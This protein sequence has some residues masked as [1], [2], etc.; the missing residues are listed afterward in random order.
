[1]EVSLTATRISVR[2]SCAWARC[3]NFREGSQGP[4]DVG[5]APE[6]RRAIEGSS[7]NP[8]VTDAQNL[9]RPFR[10]HPSERRRSI[11][12]PKAGLCPRGTEHRIQPVAQAGSDRARFGVPPDSDPGLLLRGE[13]RLGVDLPPQAS[14]RVQFTRFDPGS[15]GKQGGRNAR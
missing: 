13:L 10:T 15:L 1:M 3:T 12:L 11:A 5:P 9:R 8:R 7:M 6:C 14:P 2:A 4:L